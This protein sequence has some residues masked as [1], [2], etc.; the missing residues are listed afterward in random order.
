MSGRRVMPALGHL[1]ARAKG[2][3]AVR[4]FFEAR[5]YLEIETPIL[6]ATASMEPH[7]V[8]FET[9]LLLPGVGEKRCLYLHTSPEYA[10]K[11]ALAAY[12]TQALFQVATVFRN[13]EHGP[14]H[15]HEFSLIEWYK[16]QADYRDLM[17]ETEA[18][19]R[20][21]IGAVRGDAGGSG[22]GLGVGLGV[23][24]RGE[25]AD[26]ARAF[27]RLTV[28]G[29]FLRYLGLDLD[30]LGEV[31][32]LRAAARSVG[33]APGDDWPWEDIFH[34]LMLDHIEPRLGVGVP[35]FLI[36]YPPRLAA[37]ARLRALEHGAAVAER[38]ELYVCGLE[39]CNGFSELTDPTEQ[40]ARFED[41]QRQRAALGLPVHALDE[42]LLAVLGALP[43]C[44]GNA[45]GLDRLLMLALGAEA[46]SQVRLCGVD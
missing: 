10:M 36:D 14:T 11:Q 32:D 6:R 38:F 37:L 8:S 4:G 44:A 21:V 20:A 25:E 45:L 46:I 19:V 17:D 16:P 18:L 5:G 42:G 39:L 28:R 15:N 31:E 29:A 30:A 1:R 35:C 12:P 41:E 43:P 2:L 24:W 27:E 13:E 3:G 23:C 7:L 40:R 26:C 9:W 34:L 22:V 33:S